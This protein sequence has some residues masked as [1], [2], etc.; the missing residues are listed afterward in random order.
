MRRPIPVG[1]LD[2]LHLI[3]WGLW[4]VVDVAKRL[5]IYLVVVAGTRMSLGK[6][7]R[8][9]KGFRGSVIDRVLGSSGR[10]TFRR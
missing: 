8:C 10:S 4:R 9:L 5:G 6:R 2:P 3:S 1:A 7:E